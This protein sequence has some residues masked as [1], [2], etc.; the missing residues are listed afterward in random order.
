MSAA[1]WRVVHAIGYRFAQPA[2]G[3]ELELRLSPRADGLE[4]VEHHQILVDPRPSSSATDVDAHGNHRQRV[5]IDGSFRALSITAI[6]TLTLAAPVALDP[7]VSAALDAILSRAC[8]D[9]QPARVARPGLCRE[10]TEKA[11]ALLSRAG[12]A[13]RYHSGYALP[14]ER[15]RTLPHAWLSLELPGVGFVEYDPTSCAP[16]HAHV[17][18]GIGDAYDDVA[19]VTGSLGASGAYRLVSTVDVEP[20]EARAAT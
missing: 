13:N 16:A 1:R 2:H 7:D 8:V 10:R 5:A 14:K 6:T 4:A 20:L 17:S 9:T 19:P 11:Q 18:V 15:A 3:A 12:V